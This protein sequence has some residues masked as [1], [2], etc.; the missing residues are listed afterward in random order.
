M[1]YF[2]TFGLPEGTGFG[3]VAGP[4]QGLRRLLVAGGRVP[5]GDPGH[6]H[7]HHGEEI[8]RVVSG[9]I[10][11]RVGDERR[12][13][14]AGDLAVVP[15]DTVHGFR[16]VETAVLEVFAEQ[17]MGTYFPVPEPGGGVRLVEIHTPSPWNNPPPPGA[18]HTT[19]DRLRELVRLTGLE[20]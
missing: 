13:C 11:V 9:E 1:T 16:V 19:P 8:I 6:V 7:L 17:R 4:P 10:V 3:L 12:T 18:G 15:A 14:R 2:A 20:I 5:A